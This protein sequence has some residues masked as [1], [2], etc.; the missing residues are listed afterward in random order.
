VSQNETQE[1][2]SAHYALKWLMLAPGIDLAGIMRAPRQKK[3]GQERLSL[4]TG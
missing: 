3:T 2:N 1:T 4:P